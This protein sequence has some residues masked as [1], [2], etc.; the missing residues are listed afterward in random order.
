SVK[1]FVARMQS[2]GE[3]RPLI[4]LRVDPG[5]APLGEAHIDPAWRA[6]IAA[7]VYGDGRTTASAHKFT[8]QPDTWYDFGF[9]AGHWHKWF[10]H[11]TANEKTLAAFAA[12]LPGNWYRSKKT[13]MIGVTGTGTVTVGGVAVQ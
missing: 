7:L 10:F 4:G 11:E 13:V 6:G 3:A 12:T 2:S 5:D 9:A 8:F 1:L